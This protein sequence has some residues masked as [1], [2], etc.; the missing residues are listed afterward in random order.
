[1]NRCLPTNTVRETKIKNL[2]SM[3]GKMNRV[4]REHKKNVQE[5][6]SPLD[7]TQGP[8]LL[9]LLPTPPAPG[10]AEASLPSLLG[11]AI[12]CAPLLL[13]LPLLSLIAARAASLSIGVFK[14]SGM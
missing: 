12:P 6:P 2:P 13:A 1:M 10:G 8:R 4:K 7:N 9:D 3:L 14:N 11:V 5:P